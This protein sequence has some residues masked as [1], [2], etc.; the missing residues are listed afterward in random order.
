MEDE[1]ALIVAAVVDNPFQCA[2]Q[3]REQ[4][5]VDAS[6]ATVRRR[7]RSAVL[8]NS[9]AARKPVLT[10]SNK[11]S[12][13]QFAEAHVSWMAD[14][15]GRVIFSDESTFT[16]RQDQ[17][18]RVWRTRGTRHEPA[19]VQGVSASGR[20]CVNVWGAVSRHG[21]G[22]LHRVEDALTSQRYCTEVL[23]NVLLPYAHSVFPDGD[24]MFQHDLAPVHTAKSADMNICENIWGYI[25]A[26]M[27]RKPVHPSTGDELWAAVRQEWEDLRAQ[28]DFVPALYA[29]LPS[30]MAAVVSAKGCMTK[31]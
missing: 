30:R 4:L 12:R 2:R 6:L 10:A 29:S 14:D 7:L 5:D 26:A 15:W 3:V 27:V 18:M 19:N 23:D 24:F 20:N 11:K 9:V 31:Y 22:P 25:K 21:L 16:T 28:Y 1:D 13:L 8:R 17:R